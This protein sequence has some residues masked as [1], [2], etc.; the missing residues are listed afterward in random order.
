MQTFCNSANSILWLVYDSYIRCPSHFLY[1][2]YASNGT[3]ELTVIEMESTVLKADVFKESLYKR[4]YF[5]LTTLSVYQHSF[6][7]ILI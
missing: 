4:C 6:M 7:Q 5:S 3:I 2:F 1:Y